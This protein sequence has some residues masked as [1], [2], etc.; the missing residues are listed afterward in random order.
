MK[1]VQIAVV[2]M[3]S[4]LTFMGVA[5]YVVEAWCKWKASA[6]M[7]RRHVFMF[8]RASKHLLPSMVVSL[9]HGG[10][11]ISAFHAP[12]KDRTTLRVV[13]TIAMLLDMPLQR[14]LSVVRLL[15]YVVCVRTS[16]T[17]LVLSFS[18]L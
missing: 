15:S 2:A 17:K 11:E 10:L 5:G 18:T 13:G 8:V 6:G 9:I 4:L 1:A 7:I 3:A 12:P 14:Q 16:C